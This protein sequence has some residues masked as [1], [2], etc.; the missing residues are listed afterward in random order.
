[1]IIDKTSFCRKFRRL[2][3]VLSLVMLSVACGTGSI[4]GSHDLYFIKSGYSGPLVIIFGQETG[5]RTKLENVSSV[6]EFPDNGE[7]LVQEPAVYKV[8]DESFYF[9]ADKG[10][11]IPIARLY[12]PSLLRDPGPLKKSFNEV[13]T[14]DETP[15]IMGGEMGTF[16]VRGKSIHFRTYLV[17]NRSRGEEFAQR[18]MLKMTE[19]QNSFQNQ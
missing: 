11:H 9:V 4:Q 7:L 18:L 3:T 5:V 12:N 8:D 6:F 16:N 19:I 10:E 17:G 14:N 1:M 15:Y 13:S 2:S